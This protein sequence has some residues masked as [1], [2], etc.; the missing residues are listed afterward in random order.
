MIWIIGG[1]KDSRDFLEALLKHRQ[2][3][4]VST[5]TSYGGKLLESLPLKIH[6][7]AMKE[8][9]MQSF[10]EEEGIDTIVDMTHPY[11]YEVSQNAM[12]IAKAKD[13]SYYRFE[14]ELLE[15]LAEKHQLFR[16]VEAILSYLEKGEGKVFVTLGSNH[17]PKFKDFA[18]KEDCYFR[19]LS[20]WDM[21]KKAE[22]QGIL[23]KQILAMQG[24][25]SEEMN[26]VM[27][28]DL[29]AKYLI[30]KRSGDTGGEAEKRKAADRLGVE[31]LYLDRP[32]I[33][34]PKVYEDWKELLIALLE[35]K[36]KGKNA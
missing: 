7:K 28:K 35:E 4:V 13:C 11:A 17:L 34:Y 33:A 18:R 21:V 3:L 26:Y 14:R 30:T 24:P 19:I 16:S 2:D 8:E 31:V 10:V 36:Q 9:E 1:T 20:K 6:S 15:N 22:E 23:P 12:K 29:G 32:E 27:M 5:A 25:F